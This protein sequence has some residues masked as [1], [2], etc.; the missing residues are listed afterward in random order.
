M[1]MKTIYSNVIKIN[2][3]K[4]IYNIGNEWYVCFGYKDI[5]EEAKPVLNG[6]KFV[7]SDSLISTGMCSY[8]YIKYTYKPSV[9][10]IKND[11]EEIF[12]SFTAEKITNGFYWND[13]NISLTKENQINYKASYDLAIQSGGKNLPIR[14]KATKN[15]KVEYM[16]FFTIAEVEDFYLA[17]NRHINNCLEDGWQKKDA[18]DYSVYQA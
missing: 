17:V 1:K 9:D 8:S 11:L 7:K 5:M 15:G 6:G 14:I 2:D 4:P 13:L 3:Y 10:T 18:I 12:N 16:V